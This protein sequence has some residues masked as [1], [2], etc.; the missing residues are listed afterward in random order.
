MVNPA[1]GKTPVGKA[2]A[3]D[4]L[5]FDRDGYHRR[6]GRQRHRAQLPVPQPARRH[7]RGDRH[8]VSGVGF[9]AEGKATGAMGIDVA[10]AARR[11]LDFA[12]AIGNFANEMTSL[13]VSSKNPLQFSDQANVE[14]IGS[15]SRLR[16]TFGLFFFDYDLDSR[17]DLLQANGHIEDAIHEVQPSQQ[18]R[19][20]AQLFWN[21]GPDARC[22]FVPIPQAQIG[23][24]ARPMVGRGA[25]YA[26]IDG[27]LDLDVLLTQIGGPPRLLRNDQQ[28]GHHVLRLRLRGTKSNPDGVGAHVVVQVGGREDRAHGRADPQL[29]LPGRATGDDRHRQGR[30]GRPRHRALAVRPVADPRGHADRQDDR[31]ARA[32]EVGTATARS[33][34]CRHWWPPGSP[35]DSAPARRTSAGRA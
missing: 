14:G 27:D 12:I 15:P 35:P 34:R 11:R 8:A 29:P 32:N 2:L 33:W 18:H 23:D 30:E 31:R 1:T 7:L 20:P 5:D 24:L 25:A 9:D 19:Q 6:L 22:C 21:Q 26:D 28:L 13:Y 4:L 17:L 16:L 10:R 3:R